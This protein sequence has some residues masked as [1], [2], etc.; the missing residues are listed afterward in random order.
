MR[1][2]LCAWLAVALGAASAFSQSGPAL[3]STIKTS[4][5]ALVET[6]AVNATEAPRK[7]FH[8]KL[9][10]P[11]TPGDFVLLY[12]KWIPGEH[13]PTGPLVDLAGIYFRGNGNVLPWHRDPVDLYAFHVEVPPGVSSIEAT[14]DYLSPVETP[15]G[16][17]EGSSATEKLAVLGW[18]WLVLYP[19]GHGS[20]EIGVQA[21]LQ[22]P[23]NWQ[24][25]SALPHTASA[26]GT[27][28]PSA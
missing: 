1:Q 3:S 11:A 26:A 10:I 13:G 18:N 4:G 8:A 20:D 27:M 22:M 21:S 23:S 24:W 14:L 9:T 25:A 19:K 28:S 5:F 15:S 17:S 16:F 7:V 6:L 2:L 12:P